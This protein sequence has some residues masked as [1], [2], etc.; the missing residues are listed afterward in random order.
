MHKGA[1]LLLMPGRISLDVLAIFS[2]SDAEVPSACC[3]ERIRLRVRGTDEDDVLPGAVLSSLATPIHCATAFDAHIKI[4]EPQ[5]ILTAGYA[6][7]MHVHAAVCEVTFTQLLHKVDKD[8]GRRSKQPPDFAGKGDIVVARLQTAS[9]IPLEACKDY[10]R[11]GKFT[12]RDQGRTVT[13]GKVIRLS[14]VRE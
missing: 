2:P 11:L 3:G 12:L 4:L 1:T 6:C 5:S 9:P 13:I 7:V 10:P 8:S 14:E